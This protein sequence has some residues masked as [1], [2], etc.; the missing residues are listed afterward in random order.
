MRI[1]L[2]EKRENFH[3]ILK[4]TL[5]KS[6]FFKDKVK[7]RKQEKFIV[8]RYLNFIATQ[9]I[10]TNV[11]QNLINEY[12]NAL[13]GWKKII[14]KTYVHL[15]V[16]KVFRKFFGNKIIDLSANF[17]EFLILG[18]NHRLRLFSKDLIFSVLLLKENERI[19]YVANDISVR[20]NQ[21]L[22]YA[23]VVF[24]S[25][26]DW[27]KEEYFAGIPLNRLESQDE[28]ESYQEKVIKLHL[29]ELLMLTK[30]QYTKSEYAAFVKNELTLIINNK[31]IQN[32]AIESDTITSLLDLLLNKITANS[33]SVSWSHG[34]FQMANILIREKKFKVIDW[35]SADKR[36]YLYDLFILLGKVRT[37][38]SLSESIVNFKNKISLLL[39]ITISP[40]II[41]LL[42]IEELRFS[43]NEEYSE[44]FYMSG[45]KTKQICESIQEYINE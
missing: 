33:I 4:E 37:N 19:G 12:S 27:L 31:S 26:K 18:G 16:S 13:V 43:V 15:A 39:N 23:P 24:E 35:E 17:G 41:I 29:E 11:F 3:F 36:Y 28:I 32:T 25:G 45:V 2:L 42:L 10:N 1:S 14:Q 5:N 34:D 8:N 7:N 40:D 20:T 44:N 9:K 21:Y 30:K 6:T 22:S 38:D